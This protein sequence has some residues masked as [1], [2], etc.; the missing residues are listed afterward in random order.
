MIEIEAIDAFASRYKDMFAKEEAKGNFF[1]Y[2]VEK[3]IYCETR[4]SEAART[5][6][7]SLYA[8]WIKEKITTQS[9]LF[10]RDKENFEKLANPT[11]KQVKAMEEAEEY[12][13][14]L[15]KL[16]SV[17]SMDRCVK[18]IISHDDFITEV[19][20]IPNH[21]I[22]CCGELYDLKEKKRVSKSDFKT[23]RTTTVKPRKIPTPVWDRFLHDLFPE[24]E[25]LMWFE[26]L[27]GYL[28]T[29][30]NEKQLS[31]ALLGVGGDGKSVLNKVL[32]ALLGNYATTVDEKVFDL[33]NENTR[34]TTFDSLQGIR[35]VGISEM[36]KG[37]R[38]HE[39]EFKKMTGSD[40]VA[41]RR[42]HCDRYQAVIQAKI[43]FF[44]NHLFSWDDNT[45]A[46]KRRL[47]I[48]AIP[49]NDKIIRD[50]ML[51]SKLEKE[52]SGVLYKAIESAHVYYELRETDYLGE[53]DQTE[54]M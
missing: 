47:R 18:R 19:D 1:Y 42:L 52:L 43:C 53:K 17:G 36:R 29:G 34:E 6:I 22:N 49:P 31:F 23:T 38:L 44:T 33:E 11:E 45:N 50:P 14:N 9:T 24:T 35:Y 54:S 25:D 27:L 21:I 26:R 8:R 2:N 28:I 48:Y 32:I 46:I 12:L 16:I 30:E 5:E 37:M 15:K 41:A 3:G 7:N 51:Y 10:E 13:K 20:T 39:S 4:N 40:P